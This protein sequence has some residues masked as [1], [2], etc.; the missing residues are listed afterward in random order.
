MGQERSC[1]VLRWKEVCDIVRGVK[2][3]EEGR[4]VFAIC[5]WDGLAVQPWEMIRSEAE[6]GIVRS[7]EGIA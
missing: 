5:D 1:D 3:R 4:P 2:G 6:L 7:R